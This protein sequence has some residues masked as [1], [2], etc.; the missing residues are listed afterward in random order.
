MIICILCCLLFMTGETCQAM[1]TYI[2]SEVM[3]EYIK[4]IV[5]SGGSWALWKFMQ[6][7]NNDNAQKSLSIYGHSH[8]GLTLYTCCSHKA[9]NNIT[10]GKSHIV[11]RLNISV[12]TVN[13]AETET[14]RKI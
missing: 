6:I 1:V 2:T 13:I 5:I 3:L 12:P 8:S 9:N 7:Y 10:K 11:T 4:R 14:Y